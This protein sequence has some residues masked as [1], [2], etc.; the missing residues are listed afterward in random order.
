MRII[1]EKRQDII[2]F[3]IEG[4]VTLQHSIKLR[5]TF[6]SFAKE[7][8]KKVV[9]DLSSLDYIDS[10]GLATL[11]QL[12][13]STK[14]IGGILNFCSLSEKAQDVFQMTKLNTVFPTYKT[15]EDALNGF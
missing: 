14:K 8:H 5:K 3:R 1:R 13:V 15:L 11:I 6:D 12:H 7:G 4:E 10:S 2:L 9:V